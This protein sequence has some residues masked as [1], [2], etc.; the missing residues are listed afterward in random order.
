MIVV[1]GG[2]TEGKL[3]ARCLDKKGIQYL[4]ST[5]TE[6]EP[7]F[8]QCGEYRF[9]ALD[10]GQMTSLFKARRVAAVIDAAHPFAAILHETI[11]RVSLRLSLPVIR[12]ER[13]YDL[14]EEAVH[15]ARVRYAES[16]PE[17]V[18]LLRS[19]SP[20]RVLAMTGVQTIGMLKPYWIEHEMKV[21]ILPSSRSVLLAREQGFPMGDLILLKPSG[22]LAEECRVIQAYSIDC[23]LVKESGSSGFLPVKIKA[24][25]ACGIRA[26]VV[27]RPGLSGSFITV[28]DEPALNREVET[29]VGGYHAEYR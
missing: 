10:E 3:A 19:L 27:K 15:S 14:P 13:N 23:I 22:Q 11:A 28:T 16:F 24:A 7:F 26:V 9:G 2:T 29:I 18:E 4:Y 17:A 12:F 20:R 8:M 1:F 21:R 5:R 25:A 6:T